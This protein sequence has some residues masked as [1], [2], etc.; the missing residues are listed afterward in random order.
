MNHKTSKYRKLAK[1][2]QDLEWLEG[3]GDQLGTMQGI[4]IPTRRLDLE[5]INKI[6]PYYQT[7]YT[8][9]RNRCIEFSGILRY[10]QI[11]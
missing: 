11:T 6:W 10:K 9:T 2:L 4:K 3:K 5:I 7:V 8:H 1:E